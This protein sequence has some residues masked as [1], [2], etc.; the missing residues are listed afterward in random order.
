MKV[1]ALNLSH[2]ASCAVIE[3]GEIIFSIE[4]ERLSKIKKDHEIKKICELLKDNFY[5]FIYYTSFN[6]NNDNKQFYNTYVL[7]LLKK[8][9]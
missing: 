7:N 5:D 1:L 2:N 9:K 3:N 8:I 4:E 6:I